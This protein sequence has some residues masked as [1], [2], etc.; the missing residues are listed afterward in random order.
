MQSQLEEAHITWTMDAQPEN[1]ELIIDPDLIEQV[2]I[3][4]IRNAIQ[5]MSCQSDRRLALLAR[6]DEADTVLLIE[7]STPGRDTRDIQQRIFIP[8]FTTKEDG[9]GIGLSLSAIMRLHGGTVIC[10]SRE[11]QGTTFSLR[12]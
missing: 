1:L 2:L 12:F 5:S 6:V 4:L 11:G 10:R 8:F 7:V 3:N 9:S